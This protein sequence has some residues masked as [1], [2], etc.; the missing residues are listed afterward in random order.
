[1][2]HEAVKQYAVLSFWVLYNHPKKR[3]GKK[4]K[5]KAFEL[6]QEMN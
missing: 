5:E 1:M 4:Q 2:K 3:T 6:L